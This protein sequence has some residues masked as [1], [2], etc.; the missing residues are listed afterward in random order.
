MRR[1]R[2][3]GRLAGYEAHPN[4]FLA[5]ALIRFSSSGEILPACSER[6][7]PEIAS[8][9]W[10]GS[11]I[12]NEWPGPANSLLGIDAR[13]AAESLSLFDFNT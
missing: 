6:V 9:A 1:Y 12:G 3:V 4:A 2:S 11:L 10:V 5:F 8:L 7:A 13:F